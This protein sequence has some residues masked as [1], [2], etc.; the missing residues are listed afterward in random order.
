MLRKNT[1]PLVTSHMEIFTR[2]Q[3]EKYFEMFI[4]SDYTSV[5][6]II[7]KKYSRNTSNMLSI[8][9]V[10]EIK[11]CKTKIAEISW[12]SYRNTQILL[13]GSQTTRGA[14]GPPLPSSPRESL[15]QYRTWPLCGRQKRQWG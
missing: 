9:G 8:C 10:A 13:A 6:V 11:M 14:D 2:V 7:E 1:D 4:I 12:N 15:G 5:N 3:T